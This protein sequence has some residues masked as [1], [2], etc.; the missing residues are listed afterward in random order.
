MV[1]W[2]YYWIYKLN[3]YLLYIIPYVFGQKIWN[4]TPYFIHKI[5]I[6]KFIIVNIM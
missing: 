2:Y 3:I 4:K 1:N 6:S 5:T